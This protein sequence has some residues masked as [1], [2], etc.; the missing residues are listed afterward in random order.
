MDLQETFENLINDP[1]EAVE[2]AVIAEQ[3]AYERDDLE[4][5]MAVPGQWR[6]HQMWFAYRPDLNALH[7][8]S[9]LDLKVPEKRFRD[10]C[11]LATRFNERLWLGHFDVWA[12][13]GSI[14]FRH[15]LAFPGGESFT[16]AQAIG[17]IGAAREAGE[18]LYPAF[19][20]MIWGGKSVEE[21]VSAA[22]FETH[23]EA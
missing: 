4:V 21:A 17:M 19:Q 9:S 8:C 15:A 18:R 22:M 11:E 10:A 6:D 2:Q 12:E 14:V 20:Y 13:D 7:M 23:G 1:L 5:H 3:Y 16:P